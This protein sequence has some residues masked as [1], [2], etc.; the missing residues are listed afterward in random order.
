ML[1]KKL[2]QTRLASLSRARLVFAVGLS[3]RLS[4]R[5]PVGLYV[6][7]TNHIVGAVG[8]ECRLPKAGL[9]FF[10]YRFVCSIRPA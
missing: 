1:R 3:V 4:V 9:I 8:S 10:M 2:R 7:P 6:R 5:P